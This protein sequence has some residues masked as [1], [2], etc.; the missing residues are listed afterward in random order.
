MPR[1]LQSKS[2]SIF[3]NVLNRDSRL[4]VIA[5]TLESHIYKGKRKLLGIENFKG[6]KKNLTLRCKTDQVIRRLRKVL[7]TV[8]DVA[9]VPESV[10][11]DG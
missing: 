3:T 5:Y 11:E 6:K 8:E 1:T 7:L 10:C 9:R 4:V 2:S